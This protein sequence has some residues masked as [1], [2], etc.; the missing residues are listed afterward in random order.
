MSRYI[1][2]FNDLIEP[3]NYDFTPIVDRRIECV[4]EHKDDTVSM[5]SSKKIKF[6]AFFQGDTKSNFSFER[7]SL[8]KT[9]LKRER[10]IS[11]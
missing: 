7:T 6:E 5:E 2:L 11:E 1:N 4:V 10:S 9:R 3:E 8:E